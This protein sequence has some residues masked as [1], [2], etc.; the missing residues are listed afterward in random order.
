MS[1]TSR[2]FTALI[3]SML[4]IFF[5]NH[6]FV[7]PKLKAQQAQQK[8]TASVVTDA[9]LQRQDTPVPS[10]TNNVQTPSERLT[11]EVNSFV[12][13]DRVEVVKQGFSG[14][15]RIR[16]NTEKLHGS[17]NLIGGSVDDITLANYHE[18][19][20][21]SSPEV[22]LLSPRKT[23]NQYFLN[24]GW[25]SP[26]TNIPSENTIWKLENG[27]EL[28]PQTSV[29]IS[30]DNGAGI[31]FKKIFS[32]DDKYMLTV[33]NIIE[34][35]SS[36]SLSASPFGLINRYYDVNK[37]QFYVSHEGLMAIADKQLKEVKYKDLKKD[38]SEDVKQASGWIAITDKYWISSI[39]PQNSSTDK[40][41]I[42]FKY[43][44][45]D[46]VDRFQNDILSA[47]VLVGS[48]ESKEYVHN[49]YIGAKKLDYIEAYKES[50]NIDLFDR[51][52]DFGSLYFLTKPIFKTLNYFHSHIGNMGISIM[53]LTVCIRLIL[54][55]LANM[56][57]KSMARMKKHMP[58]INKL[59]DRFKSDRQKQGTEM[60]KYYKEHKINPAAGC[61]PLFL[62]IP[63]F[64]SLYKVLYVTIEMR[65]APFFWFVHDLSAQDPTNILT[66]FGLIAWEAP[67]WLPHIGILPI[68]FSTTM[69]LQQ[70]L[71]PPMADETQ[72]IVMAWMPWIFL[73]VFAN[74]AAGLVIYW[75][76]N[77]IL[78]ILQQYLITKQI[79]ADSKE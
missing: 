1:D 2:L 56:S 57:Y 77:N 35:K 26:Q 39:I 17:I 18:T 22:V 13:Q 61:L 28:T 16:I 42:S 38:T 67:K 5:W 32:I 14:H 19:L 76:W 66:L 79:N 59:K 50:L 12:K 41:D 69:M 9:S 21:D 6:Y 30:Y 68:I 63:V 15:K 27:K 36:Q 49:I 64:F 58:E 37:K 23:E 71:N 65:H 48:G 70:K 7:D 8:Q 54:F 52:I 4:V 10:Q 72:K 47:P 62:Q 3:L 60:M 33:K 73:F 51:S 75:I 45:K 74:F 46:G 20:D 44:Q 31:K 55:P 34:N 78:S 53:L 40:F 25:V 43:Y 29:T 24:T 11:F